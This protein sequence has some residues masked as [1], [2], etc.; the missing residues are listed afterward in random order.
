[1]IAPEHEPQLPL[2]PLRHWLL[3]A[4][5]LMF[6]TQ[7]AA[8]WLL[9]PAMTGKGDTD[10][11]ALAGV[12]AASLAW[13]TVIVLFIIRQADLP[14][15]ATASMLVV[16]PPAAVFALTA[17]YDARNEPGGGELVD[18]LFLGVTGGALTA[19]LV[20]GAAMAIART[21]KLPTTAHLRPPSD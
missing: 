12:F 3:A 20:W 16:I 11:A 5:G 7:V 2:T 13:S 8:A 14:D 4:G 21:L 19:M 15:I 9:A 10:A 6:L 17:A 1:M 18:A